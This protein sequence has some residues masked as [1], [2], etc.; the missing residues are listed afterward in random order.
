MDRPGR[1]RSAFCSLHGTDGN[2]PN[3]RLAGWGHG[4]SGGKSRAGIVTVMDHKTIALDGLRHAFDSYMKDL[5]A[6][7][8]EAIVKSPG[9]KARTVADFTFEDTVVYDKV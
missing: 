8:E 9:G 5:E 6:L 3:V 4:K 7:S 2:P 1:G